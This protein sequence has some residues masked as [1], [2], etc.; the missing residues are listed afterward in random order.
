M[1]N[2]CFSASLN[3]LNSPYSHSTH[4]DWLKCKWQQSENWNTS[5]WEEGLLIWANKPLFLSNRAIRCRSLHT[6]MRCCTLPESI[7]FQHSRC[8]CRIPC[9]SWQ[10]ILWAYVSTSNPGLSWSRCTSVAHSRC[11]GCCRGC[12]LDIMLPWGSFLS[13][14]SH[15]P[16]VCSL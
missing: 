5:V 13:M 1:T 7:C 10:G 6:A 3:A 8:R 9:S 4:S 16:S 12:N 15:K 2:W 11:P 14:N